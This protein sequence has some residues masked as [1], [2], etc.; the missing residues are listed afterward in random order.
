MIAEALQR[1]PMFDL[2]LLRKPTFV[3]GLIARVHDLGVAVLRVPVPGALPAARA[4]ASPRSRSA[5]ASSCSPGRSSSPR[6]SPGGSPD[7]VPTRFLIGPGFLFVGVSLL[8]MRGIEPGMALDAPDPGLHRRGHRRGAGQRAAGPDRGR[9][10]RAGA[11]GHGRRASTRRSGRSGIATGVAALGAIFSHHAVEAAR[12]PEAL[13]G[14]VDGLNAI[15]LVGGVLALIAAVLHARADPPAGLR[16]RGAPEA[17]P[18][19]A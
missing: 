13:V 1:E 14:L 4:R 19:A 15:L 8:L 9:R 17:E 12:G 11:R 7:T 2:T 6:R 5:C 16:A 18:A 10:G 3:G